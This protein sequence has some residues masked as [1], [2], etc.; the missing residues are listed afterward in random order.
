MTIRPLDLL[1]LPTIYRYRQASLTLDSARSLTVGDSLGPAGLFAYLDPRRHIYTAVCKNNDEAPMLGG[2]THHIGDT[3][4]RVSFIAP[5]ENLDEDELP[6]LLE[7]LAGHA[8]AWGVFHLQAEVDEHS[9][10]FKS[11]RRV[12]F[13]VYAWQRIWN[14]SELPADEVADLIWEKA[15]TGDLLRIQI[16]YNQ[17]VPALVQA[18]ESCPKQAKGMIWRTEGELKGYVGTIYGPQGILLHPMIHP[19]MGQVSD[20]LVDLIGILSARRGRP[21]YL[22]VRSYQAWLEPVLEELGASVGS[23]QA[24]MVKHLTASS[25]TEQ[26]T[27]ANRK[28]VWVNPASPVANSTGS[29]VKALVCDNIDGTY[30]NEQTTSG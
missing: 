22:C 8:G 1:D 15:H 21:V 10:V 5:C 24:V 17:I 6:A 25:R 19:D 14:I 3:F 30:P 9:C 28:K 13:S 11:L 7:H 2:I 4:A 27:S 18:I 12:G 29:N 23:R 26:A 16:L 20:Q